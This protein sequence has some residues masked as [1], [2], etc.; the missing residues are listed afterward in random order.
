MTDAAGS[1]STVTS[2]RVCAIVAFVLA[3]IAIFFFPIIFGPGAII[4]GIV[5]TA[6]GDKA[7]GKWAIVA[8]VVGMVLGFVLGYIAVS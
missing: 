1:H 2:A 4:L 8:G 5:A 6:M 3:A 7:L